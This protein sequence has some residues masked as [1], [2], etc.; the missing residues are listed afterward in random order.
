MKLNFPPFA[1]VLIL[2]SVA[3]DTNAISAT[4]TTDIELLV[5]NILQTNGGVVVSD[6]T[7]TGGE[8]AP[9]SLP[10]DRQSIPTCLV[11]CLKVGLFYRRGSA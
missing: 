6:V 11:R 5:A 9:V 3:E 8:D 4:A 1:I 2:L 10:T 7:L